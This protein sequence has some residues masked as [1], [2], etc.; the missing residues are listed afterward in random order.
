MYKYVVIC[1]G[2]FEDCEGCWIFETFSKAFHFMADMYN[3]EIVTWKKDG[4]EFSATVMRELTDEDCERY[5]SGEEDDGS[6]Y[7]EPLL[8]TVHDKC[9]KNG[10]YNA[11]CEWQMYTAKEV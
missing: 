9:D 3:K 2:S 8:Y 7:V 4:H 6:L 1:T 11:G 10:V 5:I